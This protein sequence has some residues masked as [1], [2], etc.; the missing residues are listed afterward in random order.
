MPDVERAGGI[1]RN[2]LHYHR[3]AAR[4]LGAAVAVGFRENGPHDVL[5]GRG[6]HAKVDEPVA[7]DLG[8]FEPFG[9]RQRRDE[10][11]CELPWIAFQRTCELHGRRAG[12]VA[13]L[14]LFGPF[15]RNQR[16]RLL[17]GDFCERAGEQLGEVGFDLGGHRGAVL[18]AGLDHRRP[19]KGRI[20]LASTFRYGVRTW[21]KATNAHSAARSSRDRTARPG[22][23]SRRSARRNPPDLRRRFRTLSGPRPDASALRARACGT[24]SHS[25]HAGT[26]AGVVA[27]VIAAELARA[28]LPRV[29]RATSARDRTR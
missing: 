14:R 10:L 8:A 23:A 21:A 9:G 4:T 22:R 15:Q 26:P 24:A 28:L 25:I 19:C 1:G 18:Y 7:G 20:R 17:R 3:L 29:A 6:A 16:T 27:S 11:E 12:K 5:L 2:E 13:V